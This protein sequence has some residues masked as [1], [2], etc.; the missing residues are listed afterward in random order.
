[1]KANIKA[2]GT[3]QLIPETEIEDYALAQWF[4]NDLENRSAIQC[5]DYETP[6][7]KKGSD[8]GTN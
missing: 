1:M 6:D 2:N 7:V 3:L 5:L 8:N 4:I